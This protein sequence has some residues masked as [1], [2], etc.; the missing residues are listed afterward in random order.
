MTLVE[1]IDLPDFAPDDFA[2]IVDGETDPFATADLDITWREK[3][4]HVGLTEARRLIGHAAW[5]PVQVT[6]TTGETVDVLGLGGVMLH[7]DYRGHGAGRQVVL[8]A[9][10]RM[11]DAGGSIGLLFCL[12]ERV[13]FYRDMGWFPID[14]VVTADQPSGPITMP[15]VTCWT[16]L[17][18]GATLP[19]TDLHVEGLPF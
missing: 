17:A 19:A 4:D 8:G 2:R 13:R 11:T 16:P 7:R 5:V 10:S 14:R 9:M 12:P 6:T 15:M 1:L 3:T 18:E